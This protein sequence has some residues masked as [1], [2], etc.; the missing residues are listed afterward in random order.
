MATYGNSSRG[1]MG[2]E[3]LIE[4]AEP[5]AR[6]SAAA[7]IALVCGLV[8]LLTAPFSILFGVAAVFGILAVL[9][10][11]VGIITTNRPDVAGS[12]LTAFGTSFGL[13]ALALIGVRFVGIDTAFGDAALPWLADQLHS[14]NTRLPQPK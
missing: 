6:T 12:A 3:A 10:G 2:L 8:S 1:D 13:I 5:R 11:L 7:E 14:W 4:E 9:S